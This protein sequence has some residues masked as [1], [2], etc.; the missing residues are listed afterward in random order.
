MKEIK[1]IFTK[2]IKDTLKNKTVLIQFLMFPVL[3]VIMEHSV[4]MEGMQEHFFVMMFA[5]MYVGMAPLT[6]A[7]AI[8]SE[9]KETGTLRM[10]LI[11]NVK[12]W[13]YLIG[14]GSYIFIAC[15]LGGICFA[16]TGEYKG[17]QFGAFLAILA[18]GILIS[19]LVGG[20]IGLLCKNQMSATSVTMPVMM[21][22]SF[23]PMISMFNE[24]VREI[25]KF[26]YSWQI[27]DLVGNLSDAGEAGGMLS[28]ESVVILAVNFFIAAALFGGVYKK[29][30]K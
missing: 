16:L 18:A 28:A 3:V 26:V 1:A 15:M 4:H 21:V 9:E 6:C 10:L 13:E 12:V 8:V 17:W 27:Q 7:A 23:L 11:S 30:L 5:S 14:I 29:A 19:M 24:K 25:A 20:T 2:Q 22:F